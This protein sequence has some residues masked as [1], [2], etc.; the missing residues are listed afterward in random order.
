[1]AACGGASPFRVLRAGNGYSPM[2]GIAEV[3]LGYA[4]AS[5]TDAL[6]ASETRAIGVDGTL[7]FQAVFQCRDR[8]CAVDCQ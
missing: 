3:A 5:L 2:V 4:V 6:T 7:A 8:R 1:M